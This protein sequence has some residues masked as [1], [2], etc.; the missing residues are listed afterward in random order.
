[1]GRP[2]G[3]PYPVLHD[4]TQGERASLADHLTSNKQLSADTWRLRAL[5]NQFDPSGGSI[6]RKSPPSTLALIFDAQLPVPYPPG[7]R[8]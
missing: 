1:M 4:P 7:S 8:Q 5:V 3:R 6:S 2:G